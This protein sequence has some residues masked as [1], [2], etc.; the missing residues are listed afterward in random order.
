MVR[1][2]SPSIGHISDSCGLLYPALKQ[3]KDKIKVIIYEYRGSKTETFPGAFSCRICAGNRVSITRGTNFFGIEHIEAFMHLH[4][5]I[6]NHFCHAT[7]KDIVK[8]AYGVNNDGTLETWVIQILEITHVWIWSVLP[9]KLGGPGIKWVAGDE[10]I[11]GKGGVNKG[12]NPLRHGFAGSSTEKP[13]SKTALRRANPANKIEFVDE[14]SS[15]PDFA[16]TPVIRSARRLE[17]S[18]KRHL[19]YN[20]TVRAQKW[21]RACV[22]VNHEGHNKRCVF[23]MIRL[24]AISING[25]PRGTGEIARYFRT[26][27]PG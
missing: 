6:N 14:L 17:I 25:K 5:I 16:E 8:K 4:V 3:R 10:S 20:S 19:T 15:L 11:W 23:R 26:M 22:E 2:P 13:P 27:L 24:K 7:A 12:K 1:I 9:P 18:R 21:I